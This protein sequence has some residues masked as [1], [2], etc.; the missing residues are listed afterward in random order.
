VL[1]LGPE[2]RRREVLT[3]TENN[4]TRSTTNERLHIFGEIMLNAMMLNAMLEP[5]QVENLHCHAR[6]VG[7]ERVFMRILI[8]SIL[9]DCPSEAAGKNQAN[10]IGE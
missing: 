4:S 5:G 1:V 8:E 6:P 7:G 3:I 10:V 9:W 2:F